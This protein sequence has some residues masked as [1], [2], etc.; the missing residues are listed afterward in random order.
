MPWDLPIAILTGFENPITDWVI[1]TN[2]TDLNLFDYIGQQPDVLEYNITIASGVDINTMEFGP[3]PNGCII[4]FTVLGRIRGRGGSGGQ[5][6]WVEGYSEPDATGPGSWGAGN[7]TPPTDGEPA[8]VLAPGITVRLDADDGYIWGG[9]GG[10]A[11][12]RSVISV[13]G[14]A[15]A[16]GGGG[17]G[18]GW[19]LNPGGDGGIATGDP[20]RVASADDGTDGSAA[21]VGS[22]GATY[23]AAEVT[24]SPGGDGGQWGEAGSPEPFPP[25]QNTLDGVTTVSGPAVTPGAGGNAIDINGATL[26]F[27]GA[28][29][30]ATLVSEGRL[31]GLVA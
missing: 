19:D 20:G 31:R 5:G 17:G 7:G 13:T 14:Y 23:E 4:N 11:G 12:G 27:T 10:G 1:D 18:R 9:G 21:L 30:E 22:G 24:G 26:Q 2:Q 16:G 8:L 15:S 6:A 25:T 28:K 29:G 3:F